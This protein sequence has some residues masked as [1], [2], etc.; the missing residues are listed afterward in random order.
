MRLLLFSA[1]IFLFLSGCQ[2]D[3]AQPAQPLQQTRWM[4][5]QVEDFPITLS[6][7]SDSYRTSVQFGADNTT[8]GLSPCNSFRGTYSLNP[9]TGQLTISSQVAPR[10][11]CPVQTLESRYLDALPRTVRY[12]LAEKELRLY[13]NGSTTPHLVFTAA[14]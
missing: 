6:S 8:A 12:E 2:K 13:E 14:Q 7:Y 10:T 4:L 5:A 11:A 3:E 9:A 1:G